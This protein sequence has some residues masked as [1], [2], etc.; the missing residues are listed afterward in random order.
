[1]KTLGRSLPYAVQTVGI[2][3]G[4]FQGFSGFVRLSLRCKQPML[5]GRLK[6]KQ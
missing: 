3:A 2:K 6:A 5:S 1:M 4:V